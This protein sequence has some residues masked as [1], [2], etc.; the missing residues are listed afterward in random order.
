MDVFKLLLSVVDRGLE[1][2]NTREATRDRRELADLRT[3]YYEEKKKAHPNM[4]LLDDI[5]H[6][7]FVLSSSFAAAP[8]GGPQAP[9][10][11]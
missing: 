9:A 10:S 3:R 2:L 4:A 6:R 7:V 5:E 8:V 1:L 11:G